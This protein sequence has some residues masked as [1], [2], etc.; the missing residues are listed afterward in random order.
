MYIIRVNVD[1]NNDSDGNEEDKE[2]DNELNK[3]Q[4]E[5][6]SEVRQLRSSGKRKRGGSIISSL[7][8]L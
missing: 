3:K 8:I 2:N 4:E 7:Y 5:N 6:V 1:A